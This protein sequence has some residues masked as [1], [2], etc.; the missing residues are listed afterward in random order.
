[1]LIAVDNGA[2]YSINSQIKDFLP[3]DDNSDT[4]IP[5]QVV[6][7]LLLKEPIKHLLIG[8]PKA[9]TSTQRYL[10][11]LGYAQ[12]DD[13]SPLLPSP[14]NPQEV[15]SILVKQILVQ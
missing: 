2:N 10:H 15:M 1:M 14:S 13:W 9:I 5:S 12:M 6:S 3:S 4:T 11:Q 7:E 8:S